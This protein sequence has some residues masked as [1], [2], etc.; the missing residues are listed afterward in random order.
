MT[1][2]EFIFW[3]LKEFWPVWLVG[4]VGFSLVMFDILKKLNEKR[5]V[6]TQ[7]FE[8][9]KINLA[10]LYHPIRNHSLPLSGASYQLD[11]SETN[12]D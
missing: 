10:R 12:Q 6:F 11:A 7:H 1:T 8:I 2:K 3:L 9:P 5:R 4:A